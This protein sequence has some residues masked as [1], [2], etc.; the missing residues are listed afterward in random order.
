MTKT[1]KIMIWAVS[2]FAIWIWWFASY[3]LIS[4]KENVITSFVKET[5]NIEKNSSINY[6]FNTKGNLSIKDRWIEE[7]FNFDIKN[8]SIVTRENGLKERI[9]LEEANFEIIWEDKISLKSFDIISDNENIYLKWEY[10]DL[11]SKLIPENIWK[12]LESWKYAKIDNSKPILD[13]LWD[14]Q[15][16]ELIKELA[17]WMTTSNP[18]AYYKK[19]KTIEKLL[20]ILK[21]DDL[22]N[23]VFKDGE[24]DEVTKKTSLL[25]N[26]KLC[27]LT[28][29][30]VKTLWEF[31]PIFNKK[32]SKDD[33]IDSLKQANQFL[34]FVNIYKEWDSKEGNYKFV[35]NQWTALDLNIDYKKHIIDTWYVS[36]TEPSKKI[37]FKANWNTKKILSSLVKV[38]IEESWIKAVWEIKDW[39]WKIVVSS[40]EKSLF[41]LNW[42][43]DISEYRLKSYELNWNSKDW[44]IKLVSKANSEEWELKITS[45]KD[46][47]LDVNYKDNVYNLD[48][49]SKDVN[50]NWKADENK[51]IFNLD[52]KDYSGKQ[53]AKIDLIADYSD[54]L[55]SNYDL[56]LESIFL[57]INSEWNILKKYFKL[58][59]QEK[60][61]YLSNLWKIIYK[62]NFEFSDWKIKWFFYDFTTREKQWVDLIWNL[63][64]LWKFD[65]KIIS[66][67]KNFILD[68]SWKK[69]DEIY[70]YNLVAN[71]DW[72]E[73]SKWEAEIKIEKNKISSN[74]NFK[75]TDKKFEANYNFEF[76]YKKWESK[77]ELPKEFE[78]VYIKLLEMNVLPNFEEILNFDKN[79]NSTKLTTWVVA[80]AWVVWVWTTVIYKQQLE[81][82]REI[83]RINKL[84]DAQ[85]Y[86]LEEAKTALVNASKAMNNKDI[87][88]LNINIVNKLISELEKENLFVEDVNLIKR[89]S[90]QLRKKIK[91]NL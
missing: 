2:L 55:K 10:S 16:N 27:T 3:S 85:I 74:W 11:L 17:I 28:P 50:A 38:N 68:L 66:L 24:Y 67:D 83:E 26:E 44:N 34:S 76:D 40:S 7:W 23:F 84:Q 45:W 52:A 58:D 22:I 63:K 1:K 77:Y 15:N 13:I 12:V 89:K 5:I 59:I 60:S 56:N 31:N 39:E 78:E 47:S 65:F 87:F 32:L 81:K 46:Y 51:L 80:I 6:S 72:K 20:E 90:I 21:S 71:I 35:V 53:F 54:L 18:E 14:L 43:L 88:E 9:K 62:W 49:K 48:L 64:K 42:F 4:G 57:N 61:N 29:A 91:N 30:V 33:C 37:V 79:L 36:I 82:A 41:T 19:H 25:F 73:T 69:E 75:T 86:K 8:A 70:K